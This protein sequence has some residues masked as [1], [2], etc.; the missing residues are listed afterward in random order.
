MPVTKEAE[1]L[2]STGHDIVRIN[3]N[4]KSE[5]RKK[6]QMDQVCL[7]HSAARLSPHPP[8]QLCCCCKPQG[9]PGEFWGGSK[10]SKL[11]WRN[12]IHI[13]PWPLPL[14]SKDLSTYVAG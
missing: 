3:M 7:H 8:R 1:Q 10:Q 12:I 14:H 5:A 11:Q 9:S 13:K 6:R 4:E 2:R